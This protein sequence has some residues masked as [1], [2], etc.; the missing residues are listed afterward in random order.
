[1]QTHPQSNEENA[2]SNAINKKKAHNHLQLKTGRYV[3]GLEALGGKDCLNLR[4]RI[5]DQLA[6]IDFATGGAS[7]ARQSAPVLRGESALADKQFKAGV[8]GPWRW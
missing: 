1:M 8:D 6:V 5:V 7:L 3:N 4:T 2:M